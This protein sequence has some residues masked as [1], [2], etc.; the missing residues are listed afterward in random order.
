MEIIW[1]GDGLNEKGY[2]DSGQC[3]ISIDPRYFRPTEVESLLG[4][5]TKARQ[6]LGWVPRITFKELVAEMVQE[7]FRAAQRDELVKKHG[8]T[9]YDYHE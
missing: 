9:P 6:K 8:F 3:I 5:P 1:K 2:L 4:D 7:D